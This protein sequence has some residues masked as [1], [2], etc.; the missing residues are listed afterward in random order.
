MKSEIATK[1]KEFDKI[2]LFD[3][4]TRRFLQ[5]DNISTALM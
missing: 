5:I 2:F 4:N 1:V 3:P